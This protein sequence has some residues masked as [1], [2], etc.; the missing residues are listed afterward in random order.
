MRLRPLSLAALLFGFVA[1]AVL[2]GVS[3][4]RIIVQRRRPAAGFVRLRIVPMSAAG[5]AVLGAMVSLTPG[6]SVVDI[7]MERRE[8]LVHLLDVAGADAAVAAIRRD[9]ERRI[10]RLFPPEGA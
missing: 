9:F 3:T 7:D 2:A 8:M 1:H 4:M 6:S 5:A 10:A